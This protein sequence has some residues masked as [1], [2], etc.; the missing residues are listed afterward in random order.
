MCS[1][2]TGTSSLTE[3]D[4]AALTEEEM[5]EKAIAISLSGTSG[6]EVEERME[7][8]SPYAK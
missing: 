8:V 3:Q 1:S 5:I 6:M 4:L 2:L 7:E